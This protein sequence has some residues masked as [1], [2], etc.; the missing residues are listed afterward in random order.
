MRHK[1][2]K[3]D[4]ESLILELN[5]HKAN[6]SKEYY[7]DL[8]S[9]DRDEISIDTMNDVEKSGSYSLYVKELIIMAC[10]E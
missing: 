10:I 4:V 8:R 3:D 6:N 5:K 1:V 7:L 2:I 9:A